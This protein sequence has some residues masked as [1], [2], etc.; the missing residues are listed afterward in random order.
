M[1][2]LLSSYVSDSDSTRQL[3][4]LKLTKIVMDCL[5]EIVFKEATMSIGEPIH[6]A[7]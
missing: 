3:L 1:N 4:S 2:I 6:M 7:S 5:E